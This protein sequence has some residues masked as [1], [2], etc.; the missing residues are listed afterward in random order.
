[1]FLQKRQIVATHDLFFVEDG[2]ML[3]K[4]NPRL[5]KDR[6]YKDSG[7]IVIPYRN[8][9]KEITSITARDLN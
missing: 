1:V 4:L 7:R 6:L 5:Y 8:E 3:E 9:R 2:K